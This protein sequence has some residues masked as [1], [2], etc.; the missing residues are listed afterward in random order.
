MRNPSF[1]LI[2]ALAAATSV[3]AG[4]PAPSNETL[5]S[6]ADTLALF[7][8]NGDTLDASG[9]DRHATLIGGSYVSTRYGM[10]LRVAPEMV[11]DS[12]VPMGIDWSSFAG[13][14]VHPYTVEV[15]FTPAEQIGYGKL[16]SNDDTSDSGWYTVDAGFEAYPG[17]SPLATGEIRPHQLNHLAIVSTAAD[18]I[19]VY[20]NGQPIGTSTKGFSGPPAQAIFF[21]DDS[22]TGR[23]EQLAATIEV[24]R[25]SDVAFSPSVIATTASAFPYFRDGFETPAP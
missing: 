22:A 12:V 21:R 8:F 9:A 18:E 16:F 4:A 13:L 25:I 14:L 19:A 2:C 11:D 5:P 7:E 6:T 17:G 20:L 23:S 24:L 15:L 10:G 3:H 1:I